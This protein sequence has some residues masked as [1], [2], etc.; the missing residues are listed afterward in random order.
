M[1]GGGP[2]GIQ[3][4]ALKERDLG[5]ALAFYRDLLGS[6]P[7]SPLERNRAPV[8]MRGPDGS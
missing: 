5:R 1:I 2:D 6:A 8:M 7:I 4:A 3:M